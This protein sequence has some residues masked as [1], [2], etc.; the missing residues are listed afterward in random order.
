MHQLED[1]LQQCTVKLTLPRGG[2]GTGFFVAPGLILTCAH[3]VRQAQEEQIEVFWPLQDMTLYS[4]IQKIFDDGKTLDIASLVLSEPWPSHPCVLLDAAHVAIGQELY[5]YGYLK[6]YLNAG[7]V[8][9]INEGLTGDIPPLLK[10]KEAQIEGGLSG[11]ALINLSTGKACG[12][13]KETRGSTSAAGGGAIPTH[14]ILEQ[15]PELRELQQEFHRGDR[16]WVDVLEAMTDVSLE[17][18]SPAGRIFS[19]LKVFILIFSTLIFWL[20]IGYLADYSFPYGQALN[21]L[22]GCFTGKVE[23]K[24]NNLKR[25][26][27]NT[28]F[29]SQKSSEKQIKKLN[30]L[31]SKALFYIS[32]LEGFSTENSEN[33]E[34][35]AKAIELIKRRKEEITEEFL[36]S[37]PANYRLAR[38]LQDIF[39]HA[40]KSQAAIDLE[41]LE[42]IFS[43]LIKSIQKEQPLNLIIRNLA[44]E[45]AEEI[46][47]NTRKIRSNNFAILYRF[48]DLFN[49]LS[50]SQSNFQIENFYKKMIADLSSQISNLNIKKKIISDKNDILKQDNVKQKINLEA[51]HNEIESLNKKL[52]GYNHLVKEIR[53]RSDRYRNDREVASWLELIII[54]SEIA[55]NET[56]QP[57]QSLLNSIHEGIK[58]KWI[59]KVYVY[60]VNNRYKAGIRLS[61]NVDWLHEEA[62]FS[63]MTYLDGYAAKLN[64]RQ[65]VSSFRSF[66]STNKIFHRFMIVVEY[67]DPAESDFYNKQLN[68]EKC[69]IPEWVPKGDYSF[70]G[71]FFILAIVILIIFNSLNSVHSPAFK[72]DQIY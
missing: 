58:R 4:S 63:C 26:F 11:G 62:T 23:A 33:R 44:E 30:N 3:V 65:A 39:Y 12:M 48:Q 9:P 18:L 15:L 45:I 43:K 29:I 61:I 14:V 36:E 5:S 66:V 40:F 57:S 53:D 56:V 21:L 17:R 55:V 22:S 54:Q 46:S 31:N 67:V 69:T 1:L 34:S 70:L 49:I 10:F 24:L 71:C 59:S 28:D 35:V 60:G 2:W 64:L 42:S 16:R 6:S 47:K 41:K 20:L 68:L 32:I 19:Y 37:S 51:R 27:Q 13:V 8:S 25:E 7:P 38:E 72:T 50:A 52:D